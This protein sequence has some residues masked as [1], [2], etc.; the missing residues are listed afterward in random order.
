MLLLFPWFCFNITEFSEQVDVTILMEYPGCNFLKSLK[1]KDQFSDY[2][3]NHHAKLLSEV[4]RLL[5]FG[6][7][8]RE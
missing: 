7:F 6:I 2:G 4:K 3:L 8:F 1:K 5:Q